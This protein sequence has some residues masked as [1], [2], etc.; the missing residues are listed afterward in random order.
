M[1]KKDG[2]EKDFGDLSDQD[3]VVAA[4]L[5][6]SGLE[7][8]NNGMLEIARWVQAMAECRKRHP[9]VPYEECKKLVAPM[10]GDCEEQSREILSDPDKLRRLADVLESMTKKPHDRLQL[11]L[12][13][14]KLA[15]GPL[16]AA[17]DKVDVGAMPPTAQQLAERA[18][19][20]VD[21]ARRIAKLWKV[22][23][24]SVQRGRPIGTGKKVIHRAKK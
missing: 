11:E 22:R 15:G 10:F 24:A 3:K 17:G 7:A 8:W 12:L 6:R 18:N 14:I 21:H 1:R 9:G 4:A 23:L 2:V 5:G 13:S 20:T 16:T 19:V